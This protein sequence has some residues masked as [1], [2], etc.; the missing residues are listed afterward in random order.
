LLARK[1]AANEQ[2]WQTLQGHG[3]TPE[4]ELR[5]DFAFLAPNR[6]SAEQLQQ[7]LEEQTDY[8]VSV[9]PSGTKVPGEWIVEGT[10]QP[11]RISPEILDQ[12]VDWMI[13]AGLERDCEFD[14]WGTEI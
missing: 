9:Q 4:P 10:T 3:V 14:G 7:L 2:I 1:L 13:V 6:G 12:W 8:T 11:T 5:L